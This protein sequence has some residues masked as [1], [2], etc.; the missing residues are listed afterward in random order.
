MA[1][2]VAVGIL[3]AAGAYGVSDQWPWPRP[4]A[5]APHATEWL[6]ERVDTLHSGET[7]SALFSRQGIR[8]FI[9]SPSSSVVFDPRR[10]RPGVVF[11]FQR[12]PA[13]SLPLQVVVR[14][15]AEARVALRLVA[16]GWRA[17][18]EPVTWRSESVVFQGRIATTLADAIN[19]EVQDQSLAAA[20][21]VRL[22][23]D[24]ADIF[25]WQVDF[26]RDLRSGDSFRV[27]AERL[28]SE[29]GDVRLGRVLAGELTVGGVTHD[30]FRWSDADGRIG[31][32]DTDGRSL[33]RSFLLAPLQFRRI[34]S[35]LSESRLH[36]ILGIMRRHEGI[37]YA[38]DPGTPVMASG[39]G[40]VTRREWSDGYG[41]LIE[42]RH[43]NG[44]V[45]LYGHLQQFA[46][47]IARG[48]RV[49]QGQVIGYV[50]STGL[51]TGPHLHYEFRVDGRARDPRTADLGSGNPVP[52][53]Q[54][55]DFD[56]E[57]AHLSAMLFTGTAYA[58]NSGAHNPGGRPATGAS[59]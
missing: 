2:S 35:R 41:N 18:A 53:A 32:F 15:G 34:S 20:D 25:A 10:L 5:R 57:R 37:D 21:R 50:G 22:A 51:A 24:L 9:L 54:R 45:T 3:A 56:L 1:F 19:D 38:A 6:A 23:W 36:P 7:L 13:D 48:V 33:K 4:A 16:D 59:F 43:A 55:R 30:A 42:L 14:T 17:A 31:F 26:A 12:R 58:A 47:G 40:I 28:T 27:V 52:L 8:A 11:S 49:V 39:D 46:K 29:E 44:I